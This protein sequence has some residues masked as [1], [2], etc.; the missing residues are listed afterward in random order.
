MSTPSKTFERMVLSQEC[1]TGGNPVAR[2]MNG[3]VFIERNPAGDIKPNKKKSS[4]KIDGIVAAIQAVGGWLTY[5][6]DNNQTKSYLFADGA[7]LQT[8]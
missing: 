8:F 1:N 6:G 2:W 7:E 3:N 5:L 4:E